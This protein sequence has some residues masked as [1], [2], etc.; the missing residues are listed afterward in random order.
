[1]A[2]PSVGLLRSDS[3]QQSAKNY[4][5]LTFNWAAAVN[6]AIDWGGS[7]RNSNYT[8]YTPADCA[9]FVSQ[10]FKAGGYPNDGSWSAYTY[11]WVNNMGLRN[12]LIASGRG[13]SQVESLLGYADIINYDWEND[14]IFDHVAII[15]GL[16]PICVT[17]HTKDALNAPY[18]SIAWPYSAYL[19]AQTLVLY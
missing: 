8:D 14:G 7:A 3:P 19:Y 9:N 15:T 1:M 11:A 4:L 10:C 2:E 17:C 18:K 5:G 12:W 16:S 6:Y 13:I